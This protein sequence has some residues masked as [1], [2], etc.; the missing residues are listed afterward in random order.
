MRLNSGRGFKLSANIFQLWVNKFKLIAI[1][2]N[3]HTEAIYRRT[4]VTTG[5]PDESLTHI[6]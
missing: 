5:I 2:L 1:K 4:T 3:F 6:A